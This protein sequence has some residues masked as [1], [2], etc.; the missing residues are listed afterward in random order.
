[1]GILRNLLDGWAN[2]VSPSQF[3]A[4]ADAISD[5]VDSFVAGGSTAQVRYVSKGGNDATGNGSFTSPYLTIQAAITSITD[6]SA[7]KQYLVYVGPGIFTTPFVMVPWVFIEGESHDATI[8]SPVQANWI[9]ADFAG[10]AA[11]T[12]G[13]EHCTIGAP[14]AVNF[15]AVGST[16]AGVFRMFD[17]SI[18]GT[19]VMS[20]TGATI[21]NICELKD[22]SRVG[23][24]GAITH[25]FANIQA[26]LADCFILSDNMVLTSNLTAILTMRISN[27][28]GGLG[29]WT[30][31]AT[32]ATALFQVLFLGTSIF[33][34][35]GG[36]VIT[37]EFCSVRGGAS[38]AR[39]IVGP[40][41][42]TTFDYN[43]TVAGVTKLVGGGFNL[44]HCV[45]TANRTYTFNNPSQQG[46]RV[47]IKNASPTFFID[48]VFPP[49]SITTG[50]PTYIAPGGYLDLFVG[51]AF[52]DI[53]PVTQAGT[54][55][56]VAGISPAIPADITAN[57]RI[58]ATPKVFAG[59]AGVA[60]ALQVDRVVGTRVGGGLFLVK[61]IALATGAVVV[62]DGGT[63]DWEVVN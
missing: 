58:T 3:E 7:T 13:I 41:A 28:N 19:A 20:F 30:V 21:A 16:G 49:A 54:I 8:I 23:A 39:S 44:I 34:P 15:A 53:Q 45:P 27:V 31:N 60:A 55:Q 29:T 6:E 51:Q 52:T 57:S 43:G 46:T 63:Y 38:L 61:S 14:L 56:L 25:T 47:R 4:W 40:D 50:S 22:V 9:G 5:T 18:D 17:V 37:G 11:M 10:A 26:W 1:M 42:N 62:T 59:A 24:V 12:T 32:G 2:M 48:V 35:E 36:L 33:N